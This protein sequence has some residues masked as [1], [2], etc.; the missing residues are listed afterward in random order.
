MST[1]TN[2]TKSIDLKKLYIGNLDE[3]VNEYI[4]MQL[5]KPFGK[6]T[7]IEVMVHWMGVKKGLSRGYGFLEFDT[8][9]QALNAKNALHGKLL[10]GRPLVVSFAY[11]LDENK[12]SNS[13]YN[14]NS[15]RNQSLNSGKKPTTPIS[16]IK[17]QSLKN[18][19]TDAKIKAIER[20][21]EALKKQ[22]VTASPSTSPSTSS[23][24]TSPLRSIKSYQ[25]QSNRFKPY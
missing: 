18:S 7:S 3:T 1:I 17:G 5:F 9:E 12:Q 4:I 11:T 15:R 2:R 6:I 14:S 10:K 23:A 22:K 16:L 21:L 19:S 24:A 13:N 25:Q 8:K 20:K